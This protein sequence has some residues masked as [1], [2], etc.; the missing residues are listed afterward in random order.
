MW[1]LCWIM[2]WFFFSLFS[3]LNIRNEKAVN[4]RCTPLKMSI[5]Y[6]EDGRTKYSNENKSEYAFD[7][8]HKDFIEESFVGK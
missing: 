8:H 1:V 5:T 7:F 4:R 6:L 3:F 2:Q